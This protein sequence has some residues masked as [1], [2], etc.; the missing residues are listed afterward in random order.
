[1]HPVK[2]ADEFDNG[3]THVNT[4]DLVRVR[5]EITVGDGP[6]HCEVLVMNE[7]AGP[8]ETKWAGLHAVMPAAS[9]LGM[10]RYA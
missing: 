6:E 1:M 5:A 3:D 9:L 2:L 7:R 8:T 10:V 4:E